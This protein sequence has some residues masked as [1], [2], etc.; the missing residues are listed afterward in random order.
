MHSV[1]GDANEILKR[2]NAKLEQQDRH[3]WLEH[4]HGL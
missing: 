1:I 3:E 4:I 2:V